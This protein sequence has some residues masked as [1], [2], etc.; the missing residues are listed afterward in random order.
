MAKVFVHV[1][2][3]YMTEESSPAKKRYVFSYTVSIT[4]ETLEPVQ[5]MSRHWIITNGETLDTQEV[6]GEGVIGQQPIIKP[7][8]SYT[9]TSGTVMETPVGTMNG[10]YTMLDHKGELFDVTIPVFTLAAT[11]SVH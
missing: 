11:N 8:D 10:H 7:G 6:R 4:N 9:Y 3:H 1:M 5:L 2:P